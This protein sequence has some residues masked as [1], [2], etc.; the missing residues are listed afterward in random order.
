VRKAGPCGIR[1]TSTGRPDAD[2]QVHVIGHDFLGHDLPTTFGGDLLQQFAQPADD[3]P[4][5]TRRRY[6]GHHTT[7]RPSEHTPPG[8]W[9][10]RR[11]DT[12]QTLR[13]DT[14]KLT[15]TRCSPA[16]I[17]PTVQSRSP[18]GALMDGR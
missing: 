17:P 11:S 18:R 9:R 5:R 16:P 13:N 3:P 10:N 12:P 7:R 6:F 4:P 8:V 15:T 1:L 14:D 2:E